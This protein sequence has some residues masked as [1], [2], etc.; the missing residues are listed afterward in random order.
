MIPPLPAVPAIGAV[1]YPPDSPPESL[2]AGFAAELQAR[3]FR[4]GGLAGAKSGM[5]VVEL[6][7]GRRLSLSQNLGA[8]SESCTLDLAAMAEASGAIRRAVADSVDLVLVNKFSKIEK[9]G[10]GF[11]AEMLAAMVDGVPLLTAVPGAYIEDWIDFTGGRGDMLMPA[12]AALW[13]WWGPRRLYDDLALGVADAPVRRVIVGLNWVLVEG[14]LGTGLAQTPERGTMGCRALPSQAGRSLR[15]LAGLVRSWDPYELAVG[16][17]ACNAHY[18]RFDLVAEDANGL[19]S[20]ADPGRVVVVGGFPGLAER[21]PGAKVIERAPEPG[22]YPET[23]AE[24]LIPGA[25]SVIITSS[26]LANRSLPRLVELARDARMALVGPGAPLTPRLFSYGIDVL[27][28]LVAIDPDGLAEA[29]AEG[30]GPRDIK[31][32]C[33]QA[34]IRRP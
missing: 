5:E 8:G 18:N 28:G 34:A 25:D 13:R 21:L 9:S 16:I 31:R 7:T 3:G 4:L 26:T 11:A 1:V 2:L 24:W 32:F 20:F 12:E 17:A 19:D 23:A 30:G 22:Q 14:P 10:K 33:R 6:D 27:A 29:V 15:D